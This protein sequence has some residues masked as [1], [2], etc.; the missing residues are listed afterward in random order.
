LGSRAKYAKRIFQVFQR[1][2][3]KAQFAGTGVGLAICRKVVENHNGVITASGKP[4]EGAT[5]T[6]WLP[7]E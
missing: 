4:G 3:G 5:F 6:V 2:H 7:R 1:L